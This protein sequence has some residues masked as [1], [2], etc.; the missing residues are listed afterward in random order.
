MCI[1]DRIYTA[2]VPTTNNTQI[3]TFS[4]DTAV[5]S[6]NEDP[7]LDAVD[8]QN[9]LNIFA[10]WLKPWQIKVNSDKST[11]I[12]FT[13]RRSRCPQVTINNNPLP[14]KSEVKYFGLHLDEKLTWRSHIKAKKQH[15]SL[16][17]I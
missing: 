9:H 2:D 17:H 6:S 3:A 14:M 8:I 12:T 11:Q 7:M 16:I 13:A 10:E 15:L 1:R 5:L 4:D